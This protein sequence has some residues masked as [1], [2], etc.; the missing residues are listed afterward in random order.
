MTYGVFRKVLYSIFVIGVFAR[1]SLLFLLGNS[2]SSLAPDEGAY[3]ELSEWVS[4]GRDVTFFPSHGNGLY[5]RTRTFILVASFFPKF[6]IDGLFSVRIT[7]ILFSVMTMFGILIFTL[8][9][10]NS[11][12]ENRNPQFATVIF[13]YILICLLPSSILWSSLGLRESASHFFLF[14]SSILLIE[15]TTSNSK[16]YRYIIIYLLCVICAYGVRAQ[17][18]W[19]LLAAQLIAVI[20]SNI[21]NLK[22]LLV[23]FTIFLAF[24]GG[25]AWTS[26]TSYLYK[27]TVI[28]Q[29]P[30]ESGIEAERNPLISNLSESIWS[31]VKIVAELDERRDTNQMF[32][33]SSLT[34][35][36][37]NT[38]EDEFLWCTLKIYPYQ[39]FAFLLRPIP[40]F[41]VGSTL[42]LLAGIENIF[43][44][45]LYV[46]FLKLMIGKGV[47]RRYRELEFSSLLIF[48]VFFSTFA[49]LY[50]GNLGTGFRHKSTLLWALGVLTILLSS[51]KPRTR[52]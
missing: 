15:F 39:L 43:W 26:S 29:K 21:S 25:I 45:I 32:A 1:I 16:P 51:S 38:I 52:Q 13:V 37:C 11:L 46:R 36:A 35:P 8:R 33:N 41:D 48:L 28:V 24:I 2:P 18:V 23:F 40:L 14:I 34:P 3:A 49:S 42:Q 7:S 30:S 44:L 6:G 17:S 22:K 31:P 12:K 27:N 20:I 50:F 9:R 19:V 10:Y 4:E 5:E 47:F